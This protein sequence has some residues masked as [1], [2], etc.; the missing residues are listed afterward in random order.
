MRTTFSIITAILFTGV[1]LLPGRAFAEDG[2]ALFTAQN[3][4]K[5]H[6][7]TAEGVKPLKEKDDIVE[8]SGVGG[9]HDAAWFKQW[10]KKE[11]DKESK[12]KPGEKVKHKAAW[13][14]TDPE[15]DALAGWLK[16]LTKKA[17]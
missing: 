12:A 10:L 3:C 9:D 11:V 15:L 5:C 17:K 16:T 2:K 4:V 1:T 14:G 6:R 13:K 7:I 8:L